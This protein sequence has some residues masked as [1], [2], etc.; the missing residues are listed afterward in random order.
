MNNFLGAYGTFLGITI[1][2]IFGII[3]IYYVIIWLLNFYYKTKF[4]KIYGIYIPKGF[5]VRR[6]KTEYNGDYELNYPK[7][8]YANKNGSRNKVRKNNNLIYYTCNLYYKDFRITTKSPINMINLVHEFRGIFGDNSI[9]KNIEEI[10]KYEEIE[11]ELKLYNK[12][13]D[14]QSIIDQCR[15]EPTKFEEFCAKLYKKMGYTV[16]ITP[17][18]ND[19]GYDLILHKNKEKSIV[20]CKCYALR[21]SVGRPLIQKLVGANQTAQADKI[22]FITTSYF[23]KEAIQYAHEINVELIDGETLIN[24][25]QQYFDNNSKNNINI[26]R[27]D[28]EL[29]KND[30]KKYYP[31]DIEI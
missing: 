9:H 10:K 14:I 30:I 8:L 12:N 15:D 21:H 28:W 2:L 25:T 6:N 22:I 11:K 29:T 19:G 16:K 20:E 31:P 27:K 13:N 1:G 3:V 23:S 26:N 4:K 24:L 7:W 18:V 17:K 5:K